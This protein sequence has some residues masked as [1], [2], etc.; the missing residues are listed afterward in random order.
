MKRII[1]FYEHV[2]REL[3]SIR[4]IG[5]KLEKSKKFNVCIFSIV[6]EW[7]DAMGVRTFFRTA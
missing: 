1:F 3:D 5:E 2:N 6:F 4:R 7:C